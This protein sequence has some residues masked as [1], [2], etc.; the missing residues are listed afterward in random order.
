MSLLHFDEARFRRQV[1]ATLKKVQTILDNTR[2]PTY[3]ADVQHCYD[4]KYGLAEFLANTSIAAGH[5][6]LAQLGL[7]AASMQQ[8]VSWA[9][10]GRHVTLRFQA[11]EKCAFAREV[12]RKVEGA[13][14]VSESSLF[15]KSS[16]KVVTNVTEYFWTFSASW[17]L[18]AHINAGALESER[19]PLLS[20]KGGCEI[21]TSTKVAPKVE[22]RVPAPLEV[23]ITWWLKNTGSGD[24]LPKFAIKRDEKS[25]RT[26]RRNDQV[27][28]ALSFFSAL[29]AWAGA[30]HRYITGELVPTQA[31]HGLD[32][33]AIND[34]SIFMPVVALFEE[35]KKG[36]PIAAAPV[37]E[38]QSQSAPA[39]ASPS[40]QAVV[41][42][43][44]GFGS[45]LLPVGDA[46][47]FLGEQRRTFLAKT[48]ELARVF[49]SASEGKLASV[50]EA[51]LGV[52]ALH[53]QR[54]SLSFAD[55]VA[56]IESLLRRQLIA[57]VGR[58]LSA[59]DFAGFM[60]FHQ[61]KIFR[62]QFE[63]RPFC[64]AI[65]R[66]GH[67]PEGTISIEAAGAE[68]GSNG[69]LE[70]VWTHVRRI[71]AATAAPMHFAI[72][73]ATN[74]VFRGE[75]YVHGLISTVF[76]SQP[77]PQVSL[78]ARARQFS[79]FLVVIGV[80]GGASLFQPRHAFIVQNKDE[81]SIPLNLDQLPSAKAFRDAIESLSP[82]QQRFARA[83]RSMQLEGS[84]FGVCVVQLKPQLE[85]LLRLPEDSLTKEIRLTQDLLELFIKYQIPSDLL[86]YDGEPGA[87][88]T[89]KVAQV[90]GHV[91]NMLAM[92]QQAKDKEEAER[93]QEASYAVFGSMASSVPCA[94]T[95]GF[96]FGGNMD[97][98]APRGGSSRGGFGGFGG[99]PP[100]GGFG[101]ALPG[102]MMKR[103]AM[104]ERRSA[105]APM[106]AME[107][108]A[109]PPPPSAAPP[110]APRQQMQ[111]QMQV[112]KPTPS[113]AA[114]SISAPTPSSATSS[115]ATRAE[116]GESTGIAEETDAPD[117]TQLPVLL[118]RRLEAL[119]EDAALRP[120][121][122]ST[123]AVWTK[124]SQRSMLAAPTTA[125]L[126]AD[127]QSRLKDAAFDLLDALS[128]SGALS[129]DAAEL[130]MVVAATH[131]FD[132]NLV[133]TVVQ[134]N[135]NPIEKVERSAMLVAAVVHDSRPDLLLKHDQID[136]F[137]LYS[138]K[139]FLDQPAAQAQLASGSEQPA[140][141][142]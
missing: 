72:N 108:S 35:G 136:R 132:K 37:A 94:P 6:C 88:T 110:S 119:D 25:C 16:T 109:P 128:R 121:L 124:R 32:M 117:W 11:E 96:S 73:A 105:A 104:P 67:Y 78:Q 111:Q 141:A 131:V 97:D 64:Y 8:L 114:P 36:P 2:A 66:P 82:E 134:N 56:Y 90:Q 127:D 1:D 87:P 43:G 120:T 74:V 31:A 23:R 17:A 123:G 24:M 122:I 84:L 77:A 9:Q 61:R 38:A 99:A 26:P 52:V 135:V 54:L 138:P 115:T 39:P 53:L 116:D 47:R 3:P 133:D 76:A 113:V 49:P 5:E 126:G 48:A 68:S 29:H 40:S 7:S 45:A 44:Q 59:A 139:L 142:Q 4:D 20:R 10:S 101:G 12:T 14:V 18:S 65:R 13:S 41:A 69:G 83:V 91:T 60:R 22:S 103:M 92:V 137:R 58:E 62:D 19:V 89:A 98:G 129:L 28:E 93:V 85:K 102:A 75:R 50:A 95:T 79:C 27:E 125:S 55:G 63:P 130:H 112:P 118:D 71:D 81:L 106:M 70:P 100:S 57:A 46:N 51:G 21:M 42:A 15:G 140:A 80:I 107:C 86:S 33:A 34:E 30:V